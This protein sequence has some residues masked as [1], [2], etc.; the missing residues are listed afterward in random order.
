M[1]FGECVC[2]LHCGSLVLFVGVTSAV[3]LSR[4]H[5]FTFSVANGTS[6]GTFM[7]EHINCVTYIKEK[8]IITSCKGH[9]KKTN[10][11]IR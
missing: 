4:F 6:K 1:Y 10:L 9:I 11:V 3:A 8:G 5:T 7:K 2:S